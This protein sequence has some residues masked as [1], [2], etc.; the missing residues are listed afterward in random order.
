MF[1][2]KII[3]WSTI[4]MVMAI[5]AYFFIETFSSGPERKSFD[6][7]AAVDPE[8]YVAQINQ[9]R[10]EKDETFR[11]SA[12]SPIEHKNHFKALSY[13]APDLDYRVTASLTPYDGEDKELKITYTDGTSDTYE[14]YAW[15]N[16]N[17]EGLQQRLL[18]LKHEGTISLLYRDGTTG[19]ETYGGGR[20]LDF[21]LDDVKGD[22]LLIDF[23]LA[24]NPYCAYNPTYA[25]PLPPAENTLKV[26]IRAGEKYNA[27]IH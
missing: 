1:K 12:D 14:R 11:T 2:N 23:N 24:Y 9:Q 22:S 7:I 26:P 18:L 17:I 8:E 27:E 3:R 4:V 5:L 21:T 15:A 19:D 25:C 13:F 20:Y 6:A 10:A 16:F